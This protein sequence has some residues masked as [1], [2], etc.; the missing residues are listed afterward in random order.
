MT[1]QEPRDRQP[2]E[3]SSTETAETPGTGEAA[4]EATGP[5]AHGE[6]SVPPPGSQEMGST[7][8]VARQVHDATSERRESQPTVDER[9]T[10]GFTERDEE[11]V[12]EPDQP[13]AEAGTAT[14]VTGVPESISTTHEA[15]GLTTLEETIEVPA[16]ENDRF[17]ELM[18]K[19]KR[20][21]LTDPEA[22]ELG[23]LV[24]E[25]EGQSHWSAQS[26]REQQGP[27]PQG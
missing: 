3:P 5:A 23:K 15:E 24:A 17:S 26:N 18:A 22:E 8:D 1:D 13:V 14:E 7:A 4:R 21:G 27:D 16:G 10:T 25:R 9:V 12:T 6:E 19:R 2:V 11:R 20:I